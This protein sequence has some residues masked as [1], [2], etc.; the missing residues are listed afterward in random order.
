MSALHPRS[1]AAGSFRGS[2]RVGRWWPLTCLVVLCLASTAGHGGND[3]WDQLKKTIE[4]KQKKNQQQQQVQQQQ[5]KNQGQQ[6]GQQSNQAANAVQQ[7]SI[8]E[9]RIKA[10][11]IRGLELGMDLAAVSDLLKSQYPDYAVMPLNYK[12][13]GQ[14]W[15]GVLAAMPRSKHK[16]EVILVDFS[17]PPSPARAIAITRYKEFPANATPSLENL[18]TSLRKKYGGWTKAEPT[19]RGGYR[20]IY[21][22]R[23][24]PEA[25]IGER[26]YATFGRMQKIIKEDGL[27]RVLGD[28]YGDASQYVTAFREYAELNN[29]TPTC[30]KQIAVE[31][32]YRPDLNLS[33]VNRIVTVVADFEAYYKAEV[34]FSQMATNFR[35]QQAQQAVEQGGEPE[36]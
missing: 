20:K 35:K 24:T 12:S 25:C 8:P 16:S 22:W 19:Q 10:F 29:K 27:S 34:G 17:Q 26:L 15:T 28:A 33:P 13:Y 9:T 14:Q 7:A 30:Q 5:Q 1:T 18:E 31:A 36:L 6:A 11:D 21:N 2:T 32:S 3:F 23:T 4:E